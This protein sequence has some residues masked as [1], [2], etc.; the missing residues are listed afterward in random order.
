V[1][2][3]GIFAAHRD[4]W[5]AKP[6]LRRYYREEIFER[7]EAEMRPGA[8]LEIGTGAGFFADYR[9]GMTGIDVV[10]D[11]P[12]AVP[13]DVHRMPFGEGAFANVVGV[14]V[15]HHLARPGEALREIARVL[16]PG[17]R[18]ILVEPW[19]GPLGRLFYRYLHHEECAAVAEPWLAAFPPGKD[20]MD[21][22]A[23][24]PWTVLAARASELTRHAPLAVRRC[25]PFG[26]LSYVA[27]GGFQSFGLPWFVVDGL[28]RIE[29]L[30][31][32]AALRA[33]SLRALFVLERIEAPA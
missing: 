30:L 1:S 3:A 12:S 6:A 19:A 4:A 15:L 24:I 26:G 14:D 31:P 27:T 2:G 10:P 21:G 25:V 32:D 28:R 5:Q 9:P 22:N 33:A 11:H 23:M 16:Q 18:L 20:A 29:S 13:G 7:I 17:G 8:T